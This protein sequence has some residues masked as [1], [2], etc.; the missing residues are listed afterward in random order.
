MG[1]TSM[2]QSHAVTST[3]TVE[4][5]QAGTHTIKGSITNVYTEN[6][7]SGWE[8]NPAGIA[9][10]LKD[11]TG[12][13]IK[14]SLDAFPVRYHPSSAANGDEGN[15]LADHI[16]WAGTKTEEVHGDDAKVVDNDYCRTVQGDYR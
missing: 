11:P 12:T 15:L 13:I 5:V 4:N 10:T 7:G 6:A 9:W 2:F 16:S 3:F 8:R 1:Q 14:T